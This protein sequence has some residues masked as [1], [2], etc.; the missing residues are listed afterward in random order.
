MEVGYHTHAG[1]L[2]LTQGYGVAGQQIVNA[3]QK[4]GHT[5]PFN[6][7]EAAV[8]INFTQPVYYQFWENQYVIGYTPWESTGLED[9]WN[10]LMNKCDEVWTTSD[11]CA[12]VFRQN[13]V[14]KP[15]YV[16]EHGIDHDWSPWRR[17]S[18]PKVLKFL[19]HGEPALRKCGQMAFNAFE[20]LFGNDPRYSMTIKSNGPTV[21]RSRYPDGSIAKVSDT[22]NNV[23]IITNLLDKHELISL[24]KQ[25]DVLIYPSLGEGFGLI[26]LQAMAT[27]MPV[28]MNTTWAPYR[29]FSVGLD[30]NDR[31]IPSPHPGVHPGEVLQPDF[32]SLKQQMQ[33]AAEN[34]ESFSEPAYE[35]APAIHEAYDWTNLTL[36][37]FD[38]I[39]K[40][41][42]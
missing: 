30:I 31:L 20:E 39:V 21:V 34:F 16:Y 8:Q 14:T 27:G 18:K 37:A 26:P 24:Y 7:S 42:S 1:G 33:R 5:T 29:R 32:E 40:R 2:D 9:N 17:K 19:H 4:L 41:F 11:W 13:G 15:L 23:R 6:H 35:N 22:N 3:L 36:K 38:H 25:H 28:I 12:E 10:N